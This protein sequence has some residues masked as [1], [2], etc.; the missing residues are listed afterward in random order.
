MKPTKRPAAAPAA[1]AA[2]KP[3]DVKT[4]VELPAEVWRAAK[5]RAMDDY[6]DLRTVITSALRAYLRAPQEGSRHDG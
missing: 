1:P 6:S 2:T 5:I 4:T 3:R